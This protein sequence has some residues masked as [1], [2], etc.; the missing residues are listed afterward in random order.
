MPFILTQNTHRLA[1]VGHVS[2]SADGQLLDQVFFFLR[3]LYDTKII[4]K[5][6]KDIL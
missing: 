2:E 5:V 1:V 3:Y 6:Y 4:V